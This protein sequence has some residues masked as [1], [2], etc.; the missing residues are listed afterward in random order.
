[1]QVKNQYDLI[2]V[3]DQLSGYFLAAGAAQAGFKVLVVEGSTTPTAV[4]ETPSGDFLTDLSWEPFFGLVEGGIA[5][6]FLKSLGLYSFANEI[7]PLMD[8]PLQVITPKFR[9]DFFCEAQKLAQEWKREWPEYGAQLG[10]LADESLKANFK[11]ENR[12]FSDLVQGL[13]L[14]VSVENLGSMQLALFSALL[15]KTL[16]CSAYRLSLLRA[17]AG[18]RYIVGGKSALKE[19]LIGRLQVYGGSIK[20]GAWAEEIVFENGNLAGVL[21]SSFEGFIRSPR[22]VGAM[23][24]KR[25]MQLVPQ[26]FRPSAIQKEV[27]ALQPKYWR[28]SFC[29]HIAEEMI[30]EA[31]GQHFASLD[32]DTPLVEDN[33]IQVFSFGKN[34]YSGIPVGKRALLARVLVPFVE[35]S[36]DPSYLSGVI[37]RS[38]RHL[39]KIL[40][41]LESAD[42][43]LY[44]NPDALRE[45]AVYSK[46]FSFS[47][48]DLI[49][50]SLLVYDEI[51]DKYCE[52]GISMDWGMHGVAGVGYCSRDVN[53]LYGMYGEVMAAKEYVDLMIADR[54]V[55]EQREHPRVQI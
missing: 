26:S 12:P 9:I 27:K 30:P 34:V 54:I 18:L 16:Y 45:D 3:G 36:L 5:D 25:F 49:P 37:K 14:P 35:M 21:L 7:F 44:P 13:G 55:R 29:L 22:V 40:P 50:A 28:F 43:K 48:L 15:P 52:R 53:P 4:Y 10:R 19:R 47:K 39:K 46:Y 33:F 51:L 6:L 23:G 11:A 32:L 31:L 1:V 17:T 38:V 2:V 8:P 42:F 20:R 24:A 41:L